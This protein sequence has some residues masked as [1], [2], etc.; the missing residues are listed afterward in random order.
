MKQRMKGDK[1]KKLEKLTDKQRKRMHEFAKARI[2]IQLSTESTAESEEEAWENIKRA[3]AVAGLT[4]PKNI[5][6]FDS[7]LRFVEETAYV[8]DSVWAS[9]GDSVRASVRDSVW[10]SVGDSVWDSVWDSVKTSVEA[11]VEASVGD[12]VGDSVGDSVK[13]SVKGYDYSGLFACYG[14]FHEELNENDLCFLDG[15]NQRTQ[16][17]FL[18]PNTVYALRKPRVLKLDEN[19]RLHNGSGKCYED[20]SG[21]GFYAWHGTRVPEYAIIEEVTKKKVIAEQN[22]EVRRVMIERVGYGEFLNWFDHEVIDEWKDYALIHCKE[23]V[24]GEEL[25]LLRMICPS[26]GRVYLERVPVDRWIDENTKKEVIRPIDTCKKAVSWQ[27]YLDEDS[28]NPI[29]ES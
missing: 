13:A 17:Y 10:A 3:Y 26:T 14:F 19:G 21:W 15:F 4:E 24:D 20:R 8:W 2:A 16:G 7:N 5:I 22:T 29:D 11:S 18:T 25:R 28:Y 6:W 12:F 1:M 23:E 9:V 27:F